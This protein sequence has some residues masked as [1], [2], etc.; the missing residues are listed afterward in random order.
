MPMSEKTAAELFN[1]IPPPTS[2]RERILYTALDQFHAEG[3][4]AVGLDRIL[5]LVGVTK[6]TFYN[7]FDSR[8]SLI[9]EALQLRDAWDAQH[10]ER[11]LK[12]LAGY[13]P[14]AL[15]LGMFDVLDEWF[16]HEA[17]RGCIFLHACAEFPSH[18]DPIHKIAAEHYLVSERTIAEIAAAAKVPDPAAFARQWSIL[19]QGAITQRMITGFDGAARVARSVAEALMER[20]LA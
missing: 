5:S 9:R 11:R 3:F 1:E 20:A 6:T 2:T 17:Y 7:H 10:F 8:D 16:T 12:A 14:Q 13:D 15:L 18:Q 19:V 4:H